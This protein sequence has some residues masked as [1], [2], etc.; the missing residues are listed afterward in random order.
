MLFS[1]AGRSFYTNSLKSASVA[2]GVLYLPFLQ[3]FFHL[4]KN[5][6]DGGDKTDSYGFAVV[7]PVGPGKLCP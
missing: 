3:R 4:F 7:E 1:V 5:S 2:I 6:I